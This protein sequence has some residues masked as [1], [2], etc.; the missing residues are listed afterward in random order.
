[1]VCFTVQFLNDYYPLSLWWPCFRKR[2]DQ[3]HNDLIHEE[4]VAAGSQFLMSPNMVICSLCCHIL[5][6][7]DGDDELVLGF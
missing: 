2:N 4:E 6:E 1:M 5:D 3:Y 7:C